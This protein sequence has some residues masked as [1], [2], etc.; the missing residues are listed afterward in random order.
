MNASLP[1]LGPSK[2]N[3]SRK[4]QFAFEELKL[5]EEC[6]ADLRMEIEELA[7]REELEEEP[8]MQLLENLEQQLVE[9]LQKIQV[10]FL[11]SDG[12]ML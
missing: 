11:T 2:H 8:S 9:L 4:R 6:T 5:G 7:A 12:E 1:F 10:I 3:D